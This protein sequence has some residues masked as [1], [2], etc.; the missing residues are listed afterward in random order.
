MV[1]SGALIIGSSGQG[2]GGSAGA[3]TSGQ[4]GVYGAGNVIAGDSLLTDNG[5]THN[6]TGTGGITARFGF[7]AG[8]A[9]TTSGVISLAGSGSGAA[10]ITAP[11]VA[12]TTNNPL[13]FSNAILISTA[14]SS[15]NPALCF[16]DTTLGFYRTAANVAVFTSASVDAF[17]LYNG[18]QRFASAASLQWSPNA[19][20]TSSFD[21]AL[22][23][24]SAGVVSVDTTTAGN[25]AGTINATGY[26]AGGTAGVTAGNFT[27]V[28]SITT[29]AGLVTV[30][31]GSSDE[32]LK[33]WTPYDG[34]LAEI[35]AITPA[36]YH[37]N[38]KGVEQTGL[39]AEQ[40]YVGFI[41]QDVQRAIPQA[42]TATEKARNGNEI[43]LSLDDRPIIAALVNA[44]K[45][46]H[47]R[48]A[49]LE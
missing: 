21:T 16:T 3:G 47:A 6:Y 11:S 27:S 44:V 36:S 38:A 41:A 12:G 48:L 35:L 32:R 15:T 23:R 13:T 25:S 2:A 17:A 9:G 43:Y 1:T 18:G 8:L 7:T 49:R 34:G 26:Q 10:T 40:E 37:W 19:T 14:G 22:S 33:N 42:I 30:L 24:L 45:T 39:P 5:T 31:S 46:L 29:K 28:T 4:I 20:T